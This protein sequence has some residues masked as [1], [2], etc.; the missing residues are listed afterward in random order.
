MPN[1]PAPA[2]PQ[3]AAPDIPAAATT[4]R[5]RREKS[6]GVAYALWFVLGTFGAHRFYLGRYGTGS[7]MLAIAAAAMALSPRAIGLAGLAAITVWQLLDA[8]RLPGWVRAW[9][10]P[11]ADGIA[12]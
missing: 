11:P 10:D 5:H 12:G 6:A 7:A 1:A 9:N 8:A 4:P 2:A 3:H